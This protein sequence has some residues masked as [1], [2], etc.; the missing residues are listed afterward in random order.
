MQIVNHNFFWKSLTPNPTPMGDDLVAV[1]SEA[2]GSVE[3]FK[4]QFISD[5]AGHFASGW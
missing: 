4:K 5:A 3:M 1:F 2:C